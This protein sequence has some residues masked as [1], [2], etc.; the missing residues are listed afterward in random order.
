MNWPV[1]VGSVSA[2]VITRLR[3]AFV[4]RIEG[5]RGPATS[6]RDKSEPTA[7]C[8]ATRIV[9]ALARKNTRNEGDVSLLINQ[10]LAGADLSPAVDI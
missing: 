3:Y 5:G 4:I 9:L 10:G 6:G 1:T 7:V 2:A 8:Q